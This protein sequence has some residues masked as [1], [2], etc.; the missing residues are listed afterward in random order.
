MA[1]TETS[2]SPEA[3]D[4]AANLPPAQD[5]TG[6]VGLVGTGDHKALGRL[7]IGVSLIFGMA[8]LVLSAV[9]ALGQRSGATFPPT[10]SI[11]RVFAL[12][13]VGLVLLFLVPLFIGLATYVV[14]LQVGSAT[15]AFPR[16]AAAAFWTWLIGAG[17]FI[18]ATIANGGP[19]GTSNSMVDL[20]LVSLG[21]VL[22]ALLLASLTVATTVF[23]MRTRGLTVDRVPMFAWSM[24]VAAGAW[25]VTVSVAIAN[26]TLIFLDHNQGAPSKFG[27]ATG[28]W[29]QL[30]WLFSQPQVFAW[31]IPALGI[32]ADAVATLTRSRQPGRGLVMTGIGLFGVL[33]IGAWVQPALIPTIYDQATF[34][35]VNCALSI[36][37]VLVLA[38]LAVNFRKSGGS[39][40]SPVALGMLS[41]LLLLV[42]GAG[43]I[44]FVLKPLRLHDA[45]GPAA[46][47]NLTK[48]TWGQPALQVGLTGMVVLA[49]AAAALAGIYYWGPKIT[50]HKVADGPGKLVVLLIAVATLAYGVPFVLL[51]FSARWNG[52]ADAA[53]TFSLV[54]VAGAAIGAVALLVAAFSLLSSL[55]ADA[56]GDDPWD[57][58]QSLEWA[59][60]SPPPR[61][62][63]GELA[64]V[65]SAE[66]VLDWRG[67]EA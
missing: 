65:T 59:C 30:S 51:G 52:L 12:S 23:T 3:V 25:F 35:V 20:S 7:W 4:E 31:A 21:L 33:S 6:L 28:Q 58:G 26:L 37:I 44:A 14:P 24:V 16:G 9:S 57:R 47:A 18:G 42:A 63:F 45:E 2:L 1:I 19:G 50:G 54:A 66:P 10:D 43:A 13:R 40:A 5:P 39:G 48:F 56:A 55:T 34:V 11:Q 29:S 53:D 41:V 61:G 17:M 49:G 38:G 15:V 67:E 64:E 22:L 60:P 27:V 8:A 36:P 62:N 46:L 32:A